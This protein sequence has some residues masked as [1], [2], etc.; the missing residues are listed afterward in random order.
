MVVMRVGGPEED[1]SLL[2]PQTGE[3]RNL[4]LTAKEVL[5]IQLIV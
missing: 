3:Q 4:T 2:Y 1:D 5:P